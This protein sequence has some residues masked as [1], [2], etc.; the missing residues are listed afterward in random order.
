MPNGIKALSQLGLAAPILAAGRSPR[1]SAM[2]TAEGRVLGRVV[3]VQQLFAAPSVALHRARLHR[4]LLD[5]LD[6]QTVRTGTP[7]VS[8]AQQPDS[9]AV[10]C[11][12]GERIDTELLVGADGLHSTVRSQL[13]GDGEPVYAGHTSWR[14]V[15]PPGSV[16]PPPMVSE[17]WGRGERFGVVDIG[18]GEIYWFGVADAAPGGR[19]GDVRAELLG[20][21][22]AWHPPIRALIEATPA[23]RIIRTDICDRPPIQRWHGGRVVLLGD[24]AHPMT[25]NLGQGAS[26]A[27]E[28]AV[29]LDR[30]LARGLAL[31]AAL[32]EYEERRVG[33]A[34]DIVRK[35]RQFGAMAQWRHPVAVAV[36]NTGWRLTALV[37][38]SLMSARARKLAEAEL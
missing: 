19:D 16:P 6:G 25:P 8:Y 17:S 28:D 3:D 9:V 36:R 13:V 12:N 15:T 14:G 34:N 20:R 18:F 29:V 11:G 23:E 32:R 7:V 27:I 33:R 2:M 24:A 31:E 4:I 10:T 5:A 1:H 38:A 21:F 35:S 30:C 37:P 22:G 26:Q